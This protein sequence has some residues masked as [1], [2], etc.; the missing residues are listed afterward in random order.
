MTSSEV[1]IQMGRQRIAI[2]PQKILNALKQNLGFG[3]QNTY[4]FW[5]AFK[6]PWLK[7]LQKQLTWRNI[8]SADL[9]SASQI[10]DTFAASKNS[11]TSDHKKI[12][13]PVWLE[14]YS[15]LIKCKNNLFLCDS[16][17]VFLCPIVGENCIIINKI[18]Y[19]QD[20]ARGLQLIDVM[21]RYSD[22]E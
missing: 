17:I 8:D 15:N 18:A 1:K 21:N 10:F 5:S 12:T 11:L 20:L 22:F 9:G 6:M 3:L 4:N 16:W 2:S 13:I 7:R 14:V 19:S